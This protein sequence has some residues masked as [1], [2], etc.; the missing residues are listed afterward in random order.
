MT[1]QI[2][3]TKKEIENMYNEL[4]VKEMAKKLGITKAGVYPILRKCGVKINNH[5]K[6]IIT[7]L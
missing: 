7:D 5:R 6:I 1:D 3:I 4:G 2:K